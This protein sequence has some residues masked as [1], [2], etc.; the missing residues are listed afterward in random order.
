MSSKDTDT[1][2]HKA[3][4]SMTI[5]SLVSFLVTCATLWV[6]YP[7]FQSDIG[8]F[9]ITLLTLMVI[10]LNIAVHL[11]RLRSEVHHKERIKHLSHELEK[12]KKQ[13][14]ELDTLKSNFITI[15]SH[16][17]RSP[18][19]AIRG[20]ASMLTDGSFGKIPEKAKQPLE[21]IEQSSRY[22]SFSVDDFLTVSR[23]ESGTM[24]YVTNSFSLSEMASSIVDETRRT[25]MK[26]GL[27]LLYTS[28]TDSDMQVNADEQKMK[29]ALRIL[30][31]NAMKYTVKGKITVTAHDSVKGKKAYV[32]VTD[33]GLGMS[34]EALETIFDTF[35][36]AKNATTAR[37]YGVGLGLYIARQMTE[38]MGGTLTA[39][40]KG[41]GKGSTF[42][43]ELPL[44]R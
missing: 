24:N 40:S 3:V 26:R 36:R 33:T 7:F 11:V 39:T 6:V 32:S 2:H 21:R 15:A 30:I 22:M 37:V 13:A 38:G 43:I 34:K 9:F 29:Q 28:D 10:V 18:L 16:Q 35:V 5:V 20:Y 17:L 12:V 41:E 4:A 27:V 25:A 14:G 8:A 23:I 19:T 42:I 1:H 31:D 44:K